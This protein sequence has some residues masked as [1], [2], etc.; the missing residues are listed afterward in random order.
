MKSVTRV[1]YTARKM[2][3]PHT[4]PTL[5]RRCKN[6]SLSIIFI[7]RPF[8]NETFLGVLLLSFANV[9]REQTEDIA[10]SFTIEVICLIVF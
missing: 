10:E 9:Q 4:Q 1:I 3:R 2:A 7:A 8:P 6:N 5:S